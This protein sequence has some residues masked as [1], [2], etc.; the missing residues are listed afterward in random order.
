MIDFSKFEA[1]T[2]DCYGT[3]I[4]WE[5]G[6][7]QALRPILSVRG[8]RATDDEVLGHF[9]R[10]EAIAE[11]GEYMPYREVLR[12]VVRGFGE[13]YGFE[14]EEREQDR[15]PESI[16]RWPTF[17]DTP[18]ALKTLASRYRLAIISNVDE[19]L[20]EAT[21]EKLGVEFDRI[22]TAELCRSYKPHRRNFNTALA[23]LDLPTDRVLHVAESLYHDV[24]PARE[25]G[26][27]TV[28]INRRANRGGGVGASGTANAIPHATYTD[29]ASFARA[30][31]A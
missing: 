8:I 14:P 18:E 22:V 5:T 2:F 10:L 6:I 17:R 9:A 16:K 27:T 25:L 23:L 28:W 4:D 7:L 26:L 24:K 11:G 1:L 13:A 19:E 30:A 21:H 3:L 12:S 31:T 20:F 29:M 15:L